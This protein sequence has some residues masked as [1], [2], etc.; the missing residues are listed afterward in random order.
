MW[1]LKGPTREV[2][3]VS[4]GNEELL[5]PHAKKLWGSGKRVDFLPKPSISLTKGWAICGVKVKTQGCSE[6]RIC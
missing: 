1:D 6:L 4:K 5:G 3:D 2:R